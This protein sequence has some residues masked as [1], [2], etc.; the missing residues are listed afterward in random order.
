MAGPD[1]GG[2]G[3]LTSAP[4]TAAVTA[5]GPSLWYANRASGF[6]L[7]ALLT[8]ATTAGILA[9]IAPG[10]VTWPRA[11]T[12][13]LHR[14]VGLLSMIFLLVHIGTAVADEF[15][16][17]RWWHSVVP[18]A[19]P[20]ERV[21]LGLGVVAFDLL[22][23][24][25]LTSLARRRMGHRVWRGVHLL[26]YAAWLLGALHGLG[27]GT[28]AQTRWGLAITAASALVVAAAVGA[29]LVSLRSG[30]PSAGAP[31]ADPVSVARRTLP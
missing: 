9:G 21:W 24:V 27:I 15:V 7:L 4:L 26:A 19:G 25:V 17:I 28:D 20:Y 1:R 16:D 2:D 5:A 11:A 13:A 8:L 31:T 10:S 22:L 29:R 6:I 18:F 12:Q 3:M 30:P 14:N 23:A